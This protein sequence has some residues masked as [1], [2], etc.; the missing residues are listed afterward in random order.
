MRVV[1]VIKATRISGAERH[2]LILL[3]ALKAAGVDVSL[4]LLED[5]AHPVD[6][7]VAE[8]EAAGVPVRRVPIYRHLDYRVIGRLRAA[9]RDLRP[10]IVHTHL[11]HAD[12]YGTLAARLSRV[13]T[14]IT[15]R[16][17]DDNFRRLL[18]VRLLHRLFWRVSSGG[19]AISQAIARFC[20]DVEHAPASKITTIYYGMTPQE[21]DRNAARAAL[22]RELGIPS[23]APIV[24]MVCRLIEQKGVVYGLRAFARV[25]PQFPGAHLVIAGDGSR[26]ASLEAE[27]KT[28]GIADR[29]HFLGWRD[30]APQVLAALDLLLMP[31][32]WEGFGLVMLEA[33]A[34]TVPIIGS[35]VSAIPEVIVDGGTGRLV[36]P[37]DVGGLANALAEL[38]RDDALRRHMGL[39]GQDRVESVFSVERMIKETVMWY[40][41]LRDR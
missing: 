11:I 14:V 23:A 21:I 16:H 22:R 28:L 20:I 25:A 6:D 26:R 15:S 7:M 8:L 13:R 27:A 9:L 37:R 33:M 12:L 10:D 34:Q 39:L 4:L 17:N 1:H 5:P 31:S 41:N 36:A 32:L 19:I 24:G 29:V 2:L 35:A 38:L 30:D 40:E 3:P 18:P